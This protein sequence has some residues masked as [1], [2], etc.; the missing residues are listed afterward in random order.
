MILIAMQKS[1]YPSHSGWFDEKRMYD[2][3]AL[4]YFYYFFFFLPFLDC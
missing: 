3:T 2:K 1:K 4:L